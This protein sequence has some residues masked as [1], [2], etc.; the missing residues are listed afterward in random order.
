MGRGS[1][2]Q[3]SRALEAVDEL[4]LNDLWNGISTVVR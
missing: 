4:D 3:R 1:E 2:G